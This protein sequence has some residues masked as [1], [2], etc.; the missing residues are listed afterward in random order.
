MAPDDDEEGGIDRRTLLKLGLAA[1]AGAAAGTGTFAVLRALTVPSDRRLERR[2]TF[3]YLDP[4][5][6][7]ELPVWYVDEGLVGRQAQAS[8]FEPGRG[9]NVVWR[10][11]VNARGELEFPGFPALLIRMTYEEL[12]FPEGWPREDYVV[13]GLYA[14]FNCCTHA[15]CAA[16]YKL[17]PRAQYLTDPGFDTVYCRCHATHYDPKKIVVDAH[18]D[19]PEGSGATYLGVHWIPGLGP[20]DRAMPLIPI[21]VEGD[22]VRGRM[23]HPE[24]Y[25]YLVWREVPMLQPEGK[26]RG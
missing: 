20:G 10:K 5:Q 8:D 4:S 21:E 25:Q 26:P 12:E 17:I 9:A 11:T 18:P 22:V 14:V 23:D 13:D 3:E 2:D 24:W 15:C 7:A 19:P 16:G 6:G 1:G